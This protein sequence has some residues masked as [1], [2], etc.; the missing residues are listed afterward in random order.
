MIRVVLVPHTHWDREW[1]LPFEAF[2][3]HLV[4]VVDGLLDLLE[5][6]YPHFHL[7]GQTA[8]VD[9]YL[10]VRPERANDIERHARAGRISV[11]PW[12]ALVDE[13]LVSGESLVRS[14]ELGLE[15]ARQLGGGD[16]VGYLP[17]Q[18]GHVGQMPQI[19]SAAGIDVAVVWRGVPSSV[20][21]SSFWW[22]A[23]D[24]SRVLAEYL[25]FGY[26]LGSELAAKKKP[27][28]LAAELEKLA[29][30]LSPFASRTSVL[31]MTGMDHA[32]ADATLPE[33]LLEAKRRAPDLEVEVSSLAGYL[34]EATADD[35]PVV[36][37]ELRSAA[38]AHLLPGVYATRPHQKRERAQVEALVERYA[39]PLAA[40]VPGLEWPQPELDRIWELLV[41]NGAHDSICGC[42]V[43]EVALAVDA[44]H[45]DARAAAERIVLEALES[46]GSQVQEP[47]VLRFNPS[48]FAREGV[49]GLGWSVDPAPAAVTELPVELGLR[50]GWVAADEVELAF[51]DEADVGDLYNFC[52]S[53][54]AGVVRP[55]RLEVEA[56]E[57]VAGFDGVEVRLRVRRRPEEPFLRLEGT[58][59]NERPDHRLRLHVRLPGPVDRA[60]AGAP[61]E[62]V[63]RPLVSEGSDLE[64]ASPTWPA[65]GVVLAGGVA[66][67]AEGVFEYEV[68]PEGAVAITLVRCAGTISRRGL[69]T[70]PGSAG[71]D[72][73][74]PGA[75]LIG[76]TAFSL[77]VAPR[78]EPADLLSAWE[79]FALPLRVAPA[80]GGGTLP[81]SGSL[82]QI[83]GATL[84]AVRRHD[85]VVE[86]R[87][88]NPA[89]APVRAKVGGETVALR[90]SEIAT[91]RVANPF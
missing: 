30:L 49:P 24:G 73:P 70:R 61:F 23:P 76:E 17:D 53:D 7:D 65:R 41:L 27:K 74:T 11:G 44:R 34:A 3:E 35:L 58:I 78:A 39:E 50:E 31:V 85:A 20:D 55:T 59:A 77:A 64:A 1:Y 88:W 54:G 63:T 46:L 6:G 45:A 86:A 40:L 62:L 57:C 69:A 90:P 83:E 12:L 15:R 5:E 56:G 9:D 32:S 91:I 19:L 81:S 67:L 10:G 42:S 36:R 18:F 75:Q 28:A 82:L 84:S 22:E 71:P 72:M 47:G 48:P 29:G 21:R 80:A 33:R 60:V 51:F 79:R 26:S 14:L 13:F 2:R 43:D 66:V 37:G 38:R 8:L 89:P 25:P 16:R 68:L 87:V 52:P 4:R